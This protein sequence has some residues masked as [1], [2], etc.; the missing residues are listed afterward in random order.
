MGMLP[1]SL[2]SVRNQL[3]TLSGKGKVQ[4]HTNMRTVLGYGTVGPGAEPD[5]RYIVRTPEGELTFNSFGEVE[6]AWLQGLVEPDDEIREEGATKWRKASTLPLLVQARRRGDALWGGT[7]SAWIIIAIVFAS[8]ALYFIAKGRTWFG[9]MIAFVLAL[10][11]TRVTY[12]AFK[13][14]RP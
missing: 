7:Q 4:L 11:L 2:V 12:R 8:A 9:L 14:S 10:L 1:R 5:M 3:R 13:R 6:R